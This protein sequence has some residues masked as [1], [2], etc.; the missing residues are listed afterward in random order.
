[1]GVAVSDDGSLIYASSHYNPCYVAQFFCNVTDAVHRSGTCSSASPNGVG[2]SV[3]G[4]SAIAL[5]ATEI[6]SLPTAVVSASP[7]SMSARAQR[8][9][10]RRSAR[11]VRHF[12]WRRRRGALNSPV[13]ITY[14]KSRKCVLC[15]EALS[16]PQNSRRTARPV[17]SP[18]HVGR[19]ER[20]HRRGLLASADCPPANHG[21]QRGHRSG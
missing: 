13:G 19:L 16:R 6:W 21:R 9:D 15:L 4:P 2:G 10:A 3:N 7:S 11:N 17:C 1:V 8:D 18:A 20:R 14:D 5:N 12:G